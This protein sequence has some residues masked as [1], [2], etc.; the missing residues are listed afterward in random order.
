MEFLNEFLV[1]VIIGICLIV[2]YLIKSTVKAD[3]VHD[4]IPTIVCCLGA[5]IAIGTAAS[6]GSPITPEVWLQ[7]MASGL[8]STGMWEMLT[9]WIETPKGEHVEE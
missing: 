5:G 2:G 4:F 1:P 7:G 6:A 9:H 3:R 8:A